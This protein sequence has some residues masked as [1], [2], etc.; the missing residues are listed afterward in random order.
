MSNNQHDPGAVD[1]PPALQPPLVNGEIDFAAPWQGRTFAMAV[2]LHESGAFTWPEFQATLIEVIG[3]WDRT[4]AT[5]DVYEYYAHFSEA[6]RRLLARK[7]L[8]V[9]PELAER[10]AVLAARPHG[11]DHN[12]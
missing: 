1:L 11:H 6:L 3:A 10:E 8:V 2:A 12:H 5:G 4:A 7:G 9:A